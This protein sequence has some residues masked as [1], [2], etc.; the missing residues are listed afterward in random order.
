MG[1][2]QIG[3]ND[4]HY[5][6]TECVRHLLN[7]DQAAKSISAA[8][9]LYMEKTGCDHY[10]ADEFIRIDLRY[11][12]PELREKNGMKFTLGATR[13]Y[14]DGD[15]KTSF[16]KSAINEI[17]KLISSDTR[18]NS[19]DRNLN[20]L[21][22]TQLINMFD[23]ELYGDINIQ[24]QTQT[25]TNNVQH[26][27]IY[28]GK[29]GYNIVRINSFEEAQQYSKYTS[30][31]ITKDE[32]AF[33]DYSLN[34]FNSVYFCLKNGFEDV[35]QVVG[36]NPPLDEYGL[37][38]ISVIVKPTGHIAYCTCRWNH[39]N[40]GNDEIMNEKDISNLIG[41]SFENVFKVSDR[42]KIL[43]I[44]SR[45]LIKGEKPENIFTKVSEESEG[46]KIVSFDGINNYLR[47]YDNKLLMEWTTDRL[48]PFHNG[49]G[50][51]CRGDAWNEDVSMNFINKNGE[52][53][54]N[55]WAY[56]VQPFREGCAIVQWEDFWCDYIK[57]DGHSL[58]WDNSF[59]DEYTEFLSD[60]YDFYDGVAV[61]EYGDS[62]I[63][64]QYWLMNKNCELFLDDSV[65]N[66][67]QKEP[68]NGLY[69]VMGKN[70]TAKLYNY[71]NKTG[72]PI[73]NTWFKTATQFN[74][75]GFA[76]VSLE[77]G[78]NFQIDVNGN[79]YDGWRKNILGKIE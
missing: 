67:I 47:V 11:A 37:S 34:G 77:H 66:I 15:L 59:Y 10:E 73:F 6:V 78:D 70:E 27:P 2:I 49:F 40:N 61:V 36:T 4:I 18:I 3:T 28:F 58:L 31:C 57:T 50:I 69:L 45:K 56:S 39:S 43:F 29:S 79:I 44:L 62:D 14:L 54:L 63:A 76:T 23:D 22:A 64:S 75:N 74:E 52:L 19:F 30:W 48:S 13:I 38:M 21:S 20:G 32:G 17:I 41:C 68:S 1:L 33:N 55:E 26:K 51:M 35:K 65:G 9:K 71:I 72:K 42:G 53:L 12:L 46:I 5:M 7:E 25:Q 8:I 16:Y 24:N 60:A